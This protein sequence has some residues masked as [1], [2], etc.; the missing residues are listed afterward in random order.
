MECVQCKHSSCEFPD[1]ETFVKCPG[2]TD[3]DVSRC[4][5]NVKKIPPIVTTTTSP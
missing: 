5:E 4:V 2:S 1:Y 3:R